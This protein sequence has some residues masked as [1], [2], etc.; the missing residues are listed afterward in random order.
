MESFDSEPLVL[1][2]DFAY[3][4]LWYTEIGGRCVSSLAREAGNIKKAQEMAVG[5]VMDLLVD[6]GSGSHI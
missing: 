2:W 5:L 3:L 1:L 6:D 4:G